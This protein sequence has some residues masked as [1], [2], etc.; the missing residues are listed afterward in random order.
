LALLL[1]NKERDY[2]EAEPAIPIMCVDVSVSTSMRYDT[3]SSSSPYSGAMHLSLS[4]DMSCL[5]YTLLESAAAVD[6][7]LTS[8]HLSDSNNTS[9]SSS[10]G[11]SSFIV[12]RYPLLLS[13]HKRR[14]A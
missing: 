12:D 8:F 10:S 11:G 9:S 14:Y 1:L 6:P 3:D 7:S 5:N 2:Y 4:G 13:P